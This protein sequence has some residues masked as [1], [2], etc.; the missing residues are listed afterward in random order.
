MSHIS[1]ALLFGLL[2]TVALLVE[3]GEA[4]RG[5]SVPATRNRPAS[6]SQGTRCTACSGTCSGLFC[7][8][9]VHAVCGLSGNTCMCF[10]RP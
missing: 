2:V 7:C 6:Y 5:S 3:S 9:G 8:D 10:Q 4:Q 1:K